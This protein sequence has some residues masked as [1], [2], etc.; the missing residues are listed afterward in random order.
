MDSIIVDGPDVVFRVQEAALA[1]QAL[2]G[3]AGTVRL[4]DAR[5]VHWR[6]GA[7]YLE[8]QTL[9]AVLRGRLKGEQ[10]AEAPKIVAR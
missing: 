2:A 9:V 8:P 7:R 6:P 10:G 4:A 3:A 5:T 1:E